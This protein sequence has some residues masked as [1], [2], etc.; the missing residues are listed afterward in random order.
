MKRVIILPTPQMVAT[1]PKSD[2]QPKQVKITLR[3]RNFKPSKILDYDELLLNSKPERKS[4]IDNSS[5][6]LV[7][8]ISKCTGEKIVVG[9]YLG[10]YNSDSRLEFC[11]IKDIRDNKIFLYKCGYPII[12][13]KINDEYYLATDYPAILTY[14]D[15]LWYVNDIVREIIFQFNYNKINV[16]TCP[17]WNNYYSLNCRIA[18][19]SAIIPKV[20]EQYDDESIIHYCISNLETSGRLLDFDSK[21]FKITVEN[22]CI[23][24]H[25][26]IFSIENAKCESYYMNLYTKNKNDLELIEL[27]K[28]SQMPQLAKGF[29]EYFIINIQEEV[30]LNFELQSIQ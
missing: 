14:K 19:Y 29:T 25:C 11:M 21:L 5:N 26:N 10:Y 30:T 15:N 18:I 3:N 24:Y 2:P 22:N 17:N 27:H 8:R 1:A 7:E 9:S 20:L 16:D 23:L 12:C 4:I 6:E 28:M 13:S